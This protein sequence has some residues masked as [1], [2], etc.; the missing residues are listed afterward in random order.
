MSNSETPALSPITS[1]YHYAYISTGKLSAMF[2]LWRGRSGAGVNPAFIRDH[3]ICN[4]AACGNEEEAERKALDYCERMGERMGVKVHFDGFEAEPRNQ[5]RGKLS[6]RETIALEQIEA[7]V[8][9]FGKCAGTKIADGPDGYTL[10]WA[11]KSMDPTADVVVSAL[12]A[13]CTGVALERGL[14]AKRD[15]ERAARDALD[16]QSGHLGTI[17][18][19]REFSGEIVT[20]FA[21]RD[22]DGET[23]FWIT[24][25]RVGTDLVTYIGNE[26]GERGATIR[27]KATIKRHDDYKGVKSTVV[28]RPKVLA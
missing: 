12:A 26:L 20:S 23:Y 14:I 17:G 1:V 25:V 10:F 16:A 6:V 21:K 15:A 4:L 7:G 5:R 24:K 11:D 9:P 19:R 2:T 18:E 8:Y 27:F 28:N 22:L 3:Y 13:A